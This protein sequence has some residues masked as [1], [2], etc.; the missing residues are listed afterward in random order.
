MSPLND[1]SH[2]SLRRFFSAQRLRNASRVD[3]TLTPDLAPQ[4]ADTPN[5]SADVGTTPTPRNSK[6]SLTARRLSEINEEHIRYLWRDRI[7]LGMATI[8]DGNPGVGKSLITI[9][10]AARVSRGDVMP[11]ESPSDLDG[12]A[13]VFLANTEDSAGAVIRRRFLVAGGDPDRLHLLGNV[14]WSRNGRTESTRWSTPK[15]IA[16]LRERLLEHQAKLLILDPAF[17]FMSDGF[18][19]LNNADVRA[20]FGPLIELTEQ[21]NCALILVRHVTKG[22]QSTALQKGQGAMSMMARARSAHFVAPDPSDETGTRIVMAQHKSNNGVRARSLVFRA[23]SDVARDCATLEWLGP[24]DFTA[25]ELLAAAP[26]HEE[27]T[28]GQE[29]VAYLQELTA[30][31]AIEAGEAMRLVRMTFGRDVDRSLRRARRVAGLTHVLVPGYP[32]KHYWLRPGQTIPGPDKSNDVEEP[33]RTAEPENSG[34]NIEVADG[35]DIPSDM[36]GPFGAAKL[37]WPASGE[38]P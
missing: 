31:S 25:D 4:D 3:A 9:D 8:L 15:L 14:T 12:P 22:T 11:D 20:A 6:P 36:S 7:P 2:S 19:S 28:L 17:D 13:D 16:P 21:V 27:R 33:V 10:I 26:S 38:G 30:D 18:N 24:T 1:L 35:P 23:V 5:T 37:D 32:P 34:V 29:L